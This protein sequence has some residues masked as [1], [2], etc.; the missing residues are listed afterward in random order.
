[1]G[2]IATKARR[3]LKAAFEPT[4]HLVKGLD[5]RHKFLIGFPFRDP[6]VESLSRDPANGS[7]NPIQGAEGNS[8]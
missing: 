3:L 7:I 8:R 1:M 4:Q 2:G 6:L 5:Q